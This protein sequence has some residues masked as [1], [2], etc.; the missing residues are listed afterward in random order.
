[1]VYL[2][3]DKYRKGYLYAFI[4]PQQ[5][6]QGDDMRKALEVLFVLFILSF[7][8][9][10]FADNLSAVAFYAPAS[11]SCAPESG[12]CVCRQNE[13]GYFPK[14]YTFPNDCDGKK[15]FKIEFWS[16]SI[17]IPINNKR[18]YKTPGKA[19]ASYTCGVC[20]G[21]AINISSLVTVLPSDSRHWKWNPYGYSCNGH[22]TQYSPKNCPIIPY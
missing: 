4:C 21:S 9:T 16:M 22:S 19:L 2:S 17:S 15:P 6:K 3:F 8:P 20:G 14:V 13:S 11:Y 18:I 7:S 12:R 5:P 10:L 1:M